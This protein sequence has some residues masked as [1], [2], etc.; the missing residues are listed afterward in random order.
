METTGTSMLMTRMKDDTNKGYDM[1]VDLDGW[2][3][4]KDSTIVLLPGDPEGTALE[5]ME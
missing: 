5:A 3:S 1:V 2:K 4:W